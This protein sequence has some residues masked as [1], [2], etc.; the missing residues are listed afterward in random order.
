[1]S[2]D[3]EKYAAAEPYVKELVARHQ[4]DEPEGEGARVADVLEHA[5][6]HPEFSSGDV[7]DALT[8]LDLAGEVYKPR[9][10][11]VKVTP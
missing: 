6:T 8:N 9:D 2:A 3:P 1:M 5:A 10:D 11:R 7:E 4:E